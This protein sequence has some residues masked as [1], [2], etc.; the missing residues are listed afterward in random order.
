M[1]QPLISPV[2]RHGLAPGLGKTHIL[3]HVQRKNSIPQQAELVSY[4]TGTP[5]KIAH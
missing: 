4:P 5:I 2:Q 1:S 3:G